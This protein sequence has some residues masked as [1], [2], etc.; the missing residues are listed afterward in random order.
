MSLRG[1]GTIGCR[2]DD[3]AAAGAWYAEFLGVEPS[4]EGPGPGGCLACAEPCLEVLAAGR[5]P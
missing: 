3:V 4:S 1:F 5:R 2:A